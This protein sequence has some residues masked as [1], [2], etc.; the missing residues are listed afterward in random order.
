MSQIGNAN[1]SDTQVVWYDTSVAS[2]I[3]NY[4]GG[5]FGGTSFVR[6]SLI[7]IQNGG[8]FEP[9][10]ESRSGLAT[11]YLLGPQGLGFRSNPM[12]PIEVLGDGPA[13][14]L[15]GLFDSKGPARKRNGNKSRAAAPQANGNVRFA[16]G[17]Q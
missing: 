15:N 10:Y 13:V 17:L 4:G 14:N 5:D 11:L 6:N 3:T 8:A 9:G 2:V 7:D 12:V 1:F 16:S